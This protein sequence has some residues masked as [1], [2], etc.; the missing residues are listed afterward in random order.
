[1]KKRLLTQLLALA[2]VMGAYAYN[3][4]D[5]IFS[6][7][8][9]FKVISNNFVTNGD[10]SV[11]DGYDGWSSVDGGQVADNW[12]IVSGL[13][14]NG[15]AVIQSQSS[16]ADSTAW[17]CRSWEL[18]A[19]T[20]TVSFWIQG[21]QSGTT[22]VAVVNNQGAYTT[23]GDNYMNFYVAQAGTFDIKSPILPA[24][25]FNT[26][27][28]QIVGNV[29]LTEPST[30]AFAAKSVAP[31]VCLTG[32]EIYQVEEVYDT[33]ILERWQSYMQKL[34]DDPDLP[35]EKD[36]LAEPL[37]ALN[38]FITVDGMADDPE[39]VAYVLENVQTQIAAFLDANAGD[40]ESGDWSKVGY[41]NW[42]NIN[43]ATVVGSW[44][45]LGDR[46]GFSPNDESLERPANDGYVLSA[47]IQR[48]YNHVG[49]GVKVTRSDLPAGK[50]F[51]QIEAQATA[52]AN[53]SAPYGSNSS[54]PI[55]G[56]T[57]WVGTDSL[58]LAEDTIS[59]DYWKTYYL[60]REV[61]EGETVT[62]GFLFPSYEDGLGGR[63]SLRNPQFR[64]VGKNV[65]E[66][67]HYLR[68]GEVVTQE[69]ELKN[70][71]DNYM[72][73]VKNLYW[74]KDSLTLVQGRAQA[75]YD[76]AITIVTPER[77][78]AVQPTAEGVVQLEELRDGLLA[79]VND[80]ARAKNWMTRMNSV[81]DSLRTHIADAN[82]SLAS[83][84]HAKADAGLRTALQ[85]AVATGQGLIDGLAVIDDIEG[86]VA[87]NAEHSTAKQNI[88]DARQEFE[89]SCATR[90]FPAELQ[91]ENLNFEAWT[92]NKTTYGSDREV[93]GWKIMIGAD[94][95]QWDIA[96]NGAYKHG[97]RASIW[98]GTSVGPNGK[99]SKTQTI[100][101]AGVYE[102]RSRAFSAE[103]GDQAKWAEYMNV[104]TQ[105]GSIID[106]DTFDNMVVDTVYHPNVRLFFGPDGST[107]D[108]ITL[109]KC[110]PADYL[111][112]WNGTDSALI[113]TRETPMEYAV[114]YVKTNDAEEL[115]EL[116]LEAFENG[117]TS[118]ANTFGFGDN[119]LTY[120]GKLE[121]Y[122][123]D[124]DAELQSV[125]ARAKETISNYADVDGAGYLTMKTD[126]NVGWII[127]KLMRYVGH[128]N[129]PWADGYSYV[130]PATL[131]EK[132]NVILSIKEYLNMIDLTIDPQLQGVKEI[133]TEAQP[134]AR[135]Q[136]G[137]YTLSGVKMN[138]KLA[139]G[140]Y[141]INGKKVIVK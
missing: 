119:S 53:N 18:G 132:H 114:I 11:G 23:P 82:A 54:R 83:E 95:K 102:F 109:T 35:L 5:Y 33:R 56:P 31:N 113:Y 139:P 49:K 8:A 4:G 44:Q 85:S 19:G 90:A 116:G 126:A 57:L 101:K 127:Y 128:A 45:T 27:W 129:Y 17:L 40:T 60:I 99:M 46:W 68:V 140:L 16:V 55:V 124:T 80:M 61:K 63:Y 98:R 20:Y 125:I 26:N 36:L 37:E 64:L 104:A 28:K 9:K 77:E 106:W 134:V 1:M 25:N 141:I 135:Q 118:G 103:Y 130:A 115:V 52:A 24:Q 133:A 92:S 138:G 6:P 112:Y 70:R 65:D 76:E 84:G 117:A 62:A 89:M 10:F 42:N 96:N 74:G 86:T 34:A 105:I 111:R 81:Q 50:Y 47:G 72:N 136:R 67:H 48:S 39:A 69:N 97:K 58:T 79:Q 87:K 122:T 29:T 123:A 108:S 13:G 22:S 7:T 137:V 2:C 21:E 38:A 14:P 110:A 51:F 91:S 94:G 41:K 12:K 93:N 43:N 30:V 120:V 15:E 88:R 131:Q 66:V 59:G 107:N 121:D 32:F 75:V 73:D 3:V 71:L 100:S 78:T